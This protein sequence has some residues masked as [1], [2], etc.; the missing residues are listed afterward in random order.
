ML[1]KDAPCDT[2]AGFSR[3]VARNMAKLNCKN[4]VADVEE[5]KDDMI[6][7]LHESARKLPRG[8]T[9]QL[10]QFSLIER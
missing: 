8:G 1:S 7:V 2:P 4:G 5:A 3:D 6:V 10:A 9:A